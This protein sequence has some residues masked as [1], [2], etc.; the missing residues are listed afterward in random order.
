MANLSL[1]KS[2]SKSKICSIDG[3]NEKHRALGLCQR[4]Y[5]RQRPKP[6]FVPCSIEGCEKGIEKRQMCPMHYRRWR[7]H[8]DPFITQKIHGAENRFWHFTNKN[9]PIHPRLQTRCWL[10]TG[11]QGRGDYGSLW[12]NGSK[13][14]SHRFSFFLHY[15]HWPVPECLHQC[16]VKQCVRPDHLKAGTHREN[17]HEAMQRGRLGNGQNPLTDDDIREIRRLLKTGMMQATIAKMFGV[18]SSRISRIYT[19]KILQSVV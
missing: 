17:M 14:G 12:Y 8:G 18:E 2:N 10:W 13:I 4:H 11:R 3:C 15:G 6:L 7:C 5:D 16:D 9:G 19:G 1:P